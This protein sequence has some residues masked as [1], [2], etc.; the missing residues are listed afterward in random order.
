MKKKA[1]FASLAIFILVVLLLAGWGYLHY[2]LPNKNG[3]IST[4]A[5]TAKTQVVTDKWGIPHIEAQNPHDAYFALGYTMAQDRLFQ[6]DLQRRVAQGELSEILGPSALKVD[7]MF[8]TLLIKQQA[9]LYLAKHRQSDSKALSFLDA[10]LQG[11]NYYIAHEPAPIEYTLLNVEPRPFTRLDSIAAIGYVAYTFA[12]G[13][14]RDSF[15]SKLQAQ[16]GEKD[17]KVLFPD[18]LNENHTT[19][20]QQNVELEANNKPSDKQRRVA[21]PSQLALLKQSM[22]DVAEQANQIVPA[23]TGSNSWVIGPSHSKSGSALL[24]NDPHVSVSNPGTWYEAQLSYPG[25]NSYG[26]H[27]PIMPFPL[28]G[29]SDS[30]AWALTM[31]END[32]MDLYAEEFNPDN[33]NLVK[34]KGKWTKINFYQESIKVKGEEPQPLIIR[35]TPHGPIVSDFIKGYKGKPIS[36]FWTYLHVENPVLDVLYGMSYAQNMAKFKQAI[37]KLAAPG[38]N[39]SYIDKQGN[40]AWWAAAKLID[41]PKHVDG[42]QILNGSSGKDDIL[43]YLPFS[44]NPHLVN[45]KSGIIVTANN[46]PTAK[47]TP[48]IDLIPG[49]YA[50]SDRAARIHQLLSQKKRWSLEELKSVQTDMTVVEAEKMSRFIVMQLKPLE[51]QLTGTEKKALQVLSQWDGKYTSASV[52]SSIFEFTTYHVLKDL[53]ATKLDKEEIRRYI[54][55]SDHWSFLKAYL[56]PGP[57]RQATESDFLKQPKQSVLLQGFKQAIEELTDKKG[58]NIDDW[59]WGNIQWLE[60]SHP[61]GKVKPLNLLFNLG[62]YPAPSGYPAINKFKTRK[63]NHDY[64]VVS[65]PSTRR[66]VSFAKD[67]PSWSILPTGNSGNFMSNHYSDQTEMFLHNRYREVLTD[68]TKIDQNTEATLIFSPN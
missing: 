57:N 59:Q 3:D 41:R 22:E 56:K 21:L 58:E 28:L 36:L 29:Q 34:Y 13:L 63:G 39:I 17:M 66:L 42:K 27:L 15:Y 52:G 68:K 6:M 4:N 44:S 64:R 31:F 35:V 60:F 19:I 8:R 10:F 50:P 43:G 7:K 18:Y 37:S 23:I 25:Y 5:V 9:Q 30:K 55:L 61:L 38:L 14:K 2:I 51:S 40:I 1:L 62:P 53:L 54:N 46:L 11:V 32:D 26:Y 48:P 12:Q 24:A 47:P 45:P 49:Y 33:P 16:I 20:M 67:E 65:I